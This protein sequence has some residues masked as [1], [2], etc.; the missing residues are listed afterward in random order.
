MGWPCNLWSC[1]GN[2]SW[3]ASAVS[4]RWHKLSTFLITGVV[5]ETQT[6]SLFDPACTFVDNR[7]ASNETK[8]S[9][10]KFIVEWW[11]WTS[12][13][14]RASYHAMSEQRIAK[15]RRYIQNSTCMVKNWKGLE[16]PQNPLQNEWCARNSCRW[17]NVST[18]LLLSA[19][20]ASYACM[21]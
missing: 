2:C 10:S 4:F 14:G 6:P 11:L 12:K 9:A 21:E 13:Q 18:G 15:N 19:P 1:L 7:V 3:V 17:W 16:P 5:F 20:G 8:T